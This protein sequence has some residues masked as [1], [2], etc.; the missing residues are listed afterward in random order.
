MCRF[1]QVALRNTSTSGN[2][3]ASTDREHEARS[4]PRFFLRIQHK[5]SSQLD[6]VGLLNEREAEISPWRHI[7]VHQLEHFVAVLRGGRF[8]GN[9][10]RSSQYVTEQ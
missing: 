9:E 10:M 7:R 8:Y 4:D 6:S 5:I 1:H 2:L 3:H